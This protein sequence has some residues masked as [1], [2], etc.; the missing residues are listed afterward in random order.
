M[1]H[2]YD[3]RFNP[4]EL[5][6]EQIE[7]HMDFDSLLEQYEKDEK[8]TGNAKRISLAPWYR[9]GG[10]AAAVLL[11]GF[12]FFRFLGSGI[13]NNSYD[14]EA[15]AFFES[16]PYINPPIK[17][18]QPKFVSLVIDS[19]S[20]G[21]ITLGKKSFINIPPGT[22]IDENGQKVSGNI[23]IR[24][25]A[26]NNATDQFL[27]GIP[28]HFESSNDQ[29]VFKDQKL[30]EIYAEKGNRKLSIHPDKKITINIPE[31]IKTRKNATSTTDITMYLLN[32]SERTWEYKGM[33]KSKLEKL[34]PRPKGNIEQLNRD[35]EQKESEIRQN[36]TDRI[37]QLEAS[38]TYPTPPTKP[39]K[40]DPSKPVFD[41]D[42]DKDTKLDD[43]SEYE[44][45]KWEPIGEKNKIIRVAGKEWDSDQITFLKTGDNKYR[46]I[47]NDGQQII[48]MN[49]KAVLS[50]DEYQKAEAKYQSNLEKHNAEKK[51]IENKLKEQ[52]SE[53]EKE[54]ENKIQDLIAEKENKILALNSDSQDEVNSIVERAVN[55]VFTIQEMGIWS[56]SNIEKSGI[57]MVSVI[58]QDKNGTSYSN[59]MVYLADL[60]RQTVARFY[61]GQKA[62]IK[63]STKSSP[64]EL[65]LVTPNGRIAIADRKEWSS[66]IFNKEE[67]NIL[68]LKEID[69]NI[70]TIQD[71]Y[72]ILKIGKPM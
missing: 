27:S 60:E 26:I 29:H 33:S 6:D 54:L 48:E 22:F 2:K 62:E 56:F 43:I 13:D 46:M 3:I 72:D 38:T 31:K 15:A 69:K 14:L 39:N 35:Y 47:F 49:V 23:D 42:L 4:P 51:S 50:K 17:D 7:K 10:V 20:G 66:I 58:L 24:Y 53:L 44:N 71:V 1:K 21:N 41:F 36:Y 37:T 9:L 68:I 40:Y 34:V 28:V 52:K 18:V 5:S 63:L 11:G 19:N 55:H 59:T 45:I 25:R 67:E 12:I 61:S 65:W 32:Q 8:K 57:E 30:F 70:E 16:Q 64:M